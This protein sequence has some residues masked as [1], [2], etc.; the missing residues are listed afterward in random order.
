MHR[1]V[2][3]LTALA[4]LAMAGCFTPA[5]WV[6]ERPTFTVGQGWTFD[7]GADELQATV[8]A[9]RIPI[10]GRVTD[11]I[12][13]EGAGAQARY[14]AID[15]RG[16]VF[17][18]KVVLPNCGDL[19]CVRLHLNQSIGFLAGIPF[20]IR[21]ADEPVKS[22][23]W[24]VHPELGDV[25]TIK[26]VPSNPDQASEIAYALILGT[27]YSLDGPA[28][29]TC[30]AASPFEWCGKPVSLRKH[31]VA[32]IPA[33][34]AT[35]I[36]LRILGPRPDPGECLPP[37]HLDSSRNVKILR[38]R[39]APPGT[40]KAKLLQGFGTALNL[41]WM[42]VD[43]RGNMVHS[44][45]GRHFEYNVTEAGVYFLRLQ[46]HEG[47]C[48]QA[49]DANRLGRS[50]FRI[51]GRECLPTQ[52]CILDTFTVR[53]GL[54]NVTADGRTYPLVG[55]DTLPLFGELVIM[56]GNGTVL[57]SSGER[58]DTFFVTVVANVDREDTWSV[59]FQTK[60]PVPFY[61]GGGE[62]SL[63]QPTLVPWPRFPDGW[64]HTG[65]SQDWV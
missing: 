64:Q 63:V 46:G 45:T 26:V 40:V 15:R 56:D 47:T 20:P 16:E 9:T 33:L 11:I 14:F 25:E 34:T 42:L 61:I 29:K 3:A 58:L 10:D 48:L 55:S 49:T 60:E 36:A 5:G 35:E 32:E 23:E 17:T 57:K 43:W 12:L 30:D 4:T 51:Y 7:V 21:A 2:V 41:S 54:I 65:P 13:V 44:A 24:Q 50:L 52:S 18:L 8:L 37:N 31:S 62:S 19:G 28:D 53:P 59:A 39:T 38:D 27:T 22:R 6:V 1:P